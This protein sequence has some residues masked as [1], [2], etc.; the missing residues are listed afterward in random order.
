MLLLNTSSMNTAVI[1]VVWSIGASDPLYVFGPCGCGKTNC[2][3]QLVAKLN[4]PVFEVTGHSRLEFPELIGHHVVRIRPIVI[5]DE[6]WG[7]VPAQ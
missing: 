3:K 6:I 1:L 4:Y 5:C 7:T 2:I